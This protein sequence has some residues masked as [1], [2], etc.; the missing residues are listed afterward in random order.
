MR[1]V[2]LLLALAL[3]PGLAAAEPIA[4]G[5][6]YVVDGDTIRLDGERRSVRLVGLNAPETNAC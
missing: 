2:L 6:V 1:R 5:R 3:V 4:P